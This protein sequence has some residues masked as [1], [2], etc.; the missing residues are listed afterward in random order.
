MTRAQLAALWAY[1]P[2]RRRVG[3]GVAFWIVGLCAIGAIV[4]FL[5]LLTSCSP[6][7]TRAAGSQAEVLAAGAV[8]GDAIRACY[9]TALDGG[10]FRSFQACACRVDRRFN[11]DASSAGAECQ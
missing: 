6:A 3:F 5:F 1:Q 9:V 11:L 4:W 2:R 10:T 7:A 8:Y